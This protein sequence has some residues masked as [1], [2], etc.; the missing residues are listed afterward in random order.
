[1]PHYVCTGSC[2]AESNESK[3][4]ES[5]FC[6]KEGQSLVPCNCE[7]GLHENAGEKSADGENGDLV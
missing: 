3:V 2:K 6:S 5:D 7:D 4:C 1:M